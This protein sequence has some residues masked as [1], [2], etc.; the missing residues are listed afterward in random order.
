MWRSRIVDT[1]AKAVSIILTAYRAY[2]VVL[3][4]VIGPGLVLM[5][6][7]MFLLWFGFGI[8]WGW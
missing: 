6:S 4:L 5:V 1:L 3:L 8:R 2:L 7:A